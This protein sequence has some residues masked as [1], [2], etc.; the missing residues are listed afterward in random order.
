MTLIDVLTLISESKLL[1]QGPRSHVGHVGLGS[2][3]PLAGTSHRRRPKPTARQPEHSISHIFQYLIV[4]YFSWLANQLW[5]TDGNSVC[6]CS[7]FCVPA[8]SQQNLQYQSELVRLIFYVLSE[9]YLFTISILSCSAWT[10]QILVQSSI[11]FASKVTL[12]SLFCFRGGSN[13]SS[14][15]P[16]VLYR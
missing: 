9:N 11:S 6:M 4:Q 13:E 12:F 7:Y 14:F 2:D 8:H 10:A 16:K 1:L 15:E 3:A 5:D